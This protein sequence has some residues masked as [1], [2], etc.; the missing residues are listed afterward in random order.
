MMMKPFQSI[1]RLNSVIQ[2][3]KRPN[4]VEYSRRFSSNQKLGFWEDRQPFYECTQ[5]ALP[6]IEKGFIERA[7]LGGCRA[8]V[9]CSSENLNQVY[10]LL[11]D[12]QVSFPE[13]ACNIL[14]H[15]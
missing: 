15:I 9:T 6:N 14:Q 7:L 12:L 3:K 5:Y 11:S 10:E 4:L 1:V 2:A 8:V 13:F